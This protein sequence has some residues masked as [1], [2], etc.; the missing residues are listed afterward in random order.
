MSVFSCPSCGHE[1]PIFG[2]DGVA[3]A[4][5]HLAVP[6][7]GQLPLELGIRAA[8]DAGRPVVVAEPRSAAA[9]RIV[10]IAGRVLERLEEE[11]ELAKA[12]EV[13]IVTEK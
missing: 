5:A 4:A 6:A 9:G 8:G 11:A 10:E 12:W 3:A 7:L 2:R 13:E 1:T